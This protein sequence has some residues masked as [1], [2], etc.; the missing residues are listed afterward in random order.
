MLERITT[1][2]CVVN[3]YNTLE[4][5]I[6]CGRDGDHQPPACLEEVTPRMIGKINRM[7]DAEAL[8]HGEHQ[9]LILL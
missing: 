8:R 4:N 1:D 2:E 7:I 6:F 9:K 3:N 5:T